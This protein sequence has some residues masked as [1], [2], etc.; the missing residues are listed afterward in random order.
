MTFFEEPIAQP[1][2]HLTFNQRV[3]GSNPSGLTN[4]INELDGK[5]G[6][7]KGAGVT[8]GVTAETPISCICVGG[9]LSTAFIGPAER[10]YAPG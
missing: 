3:D 4:K 7:V 2:E 6:T 8:I 9:K 5:R 10:R 1:V